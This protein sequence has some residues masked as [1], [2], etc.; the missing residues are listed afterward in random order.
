MSY[1]AAAN[2]CGLTQAL[3]CTKAIRTYSATSLHFAPDI[4]V[5]SFAFDLSNADFEHRVP[6][7]PDVRTC[8][9]GRGDRSSPQQHIH[10][11]AVARRF[12]GVK[13]NN[14]FKPNLLRGPAHAVTCTTSPYRYAGRLN[15]GVRFCDQQSRHF[16][17]D[18]DP[19]SPFR[20]FLC[21][22]GNH[23]TALGLG[24]T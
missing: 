5:A 10:P 22:T 12:H 14:S 2:R 24:R 13:P 18:S 9:P 8:A 7:H 1:H 21:S 19:C 20:R 6:A 23:R 3:G 17:H 11:R 16:T 15:S 4:L